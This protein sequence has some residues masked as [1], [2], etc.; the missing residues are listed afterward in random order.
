M[1]YTIRAFALS[2]AFLAA[3]PLGA[4]TA[5]ADEAIASLQSAYS[6]SVTPGEPADQHVQLLA[7]VLRRVER[8]Y[9]NE[10][11]F[12]AVTQASLAVLQGVAAGTGDPADLFK[13][14]IN[15]GLR[16]LDPYSRYMDARAHANERSESSG[17]FSGVG[18]E[19]E[20]KDGTVRVVAA[21]P[22]TPATR[23]GLLPGD[24]IVQVDELP[25]AGLPLSDVTAR[26]R[27][28]PGTPVSLIIRRPANGAEFT[29]VLTRDVIR[30]RLLQWAMEDDVL[31]LRLR[32]FSGPVT[33]NVEAA[34]AQVVGTTPPSAVVLDLRGNPG[35]L[36]REGVRI[37]DLFLG[38][39]GIASLR[40]RSPG[41]ARTW[42][43]DASELLAGIP[44]VVLIDERSAS[45]SELVAAALQDNG[46][47]KVM[48]RRSVGK[49]TV[50]TTYPL[51]GDNGAL[52]LTTSFY[53]APSGREVQKAGVEP[54]I[55]L[56]A[57]A[58]ADTT[59]GDGRPRIAQDR[60]AAVYKSADPG[61]AC[62][63]AY[64]KAGSVEALAKPA[65]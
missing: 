17:S 35:G 56:V 7:T 57:G 21:I 19:V 2:A 6:H 12:G 63:V 44:M 45:A 31:V 9:A 38:K 15:A 26:M 27:G 33:A 23:A 65:D 43:A 16:T 39:G 32:T 36:L 24:L 58:K 51:G 34:V 52:K 54:D 37:A 5:T 42:E 18:V 61:V 10:V 28:E 60:C 11:D 13:K 53:L 3:S 8:S 59:S 47:A 46:R 49:G 50:Q 40:G 22:D 48:G 29:V 1:R 30:R 25:L 20:A 64:L 62:A 14:A 55:E 4:A 41:S